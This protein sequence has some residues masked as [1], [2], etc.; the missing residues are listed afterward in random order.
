MGKTLIACMGLGIVN[1]SSS[2]TALA[3][4]KY[5][6]VDNDDKPVKVIKGAEK[7]TVLVIEDE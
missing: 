3:Q 4:T 6:I 2:P 5:K 1:A 7:E